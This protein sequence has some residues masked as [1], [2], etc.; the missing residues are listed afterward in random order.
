MFQIL[1]AGKKIEYRRVCIRWVAVLNK[2]NTLNEMATYDVLEE[3]GSAMF[4][5]TSH[6]GGKREERK[7]SD[8]KAG[9]E[10]RKAEKTLGS[11]VTEVK[12]LDYTSAPTIWCI[13][14]K[15]HWGTPVVDDKGH[16]VIQNYCA[17]C[18]HFDDEHI[19]WLKSPEGLAWSEEQATQEQALFYYGSSEWEADV[20]EAMEEQRVRNEQKWLRIAALEHFLFTLKAS[21]VAEDP[22]DY[23]A[24]D[25]YIPEIDDNFDD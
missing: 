11:V 9:K 8:R 14:R 20:I 17:D 7:K 1:V 13:G 23:V 22:N 2:S 4:S 19:K 6:T 21:T 10:R 5:F 16:L 15:G 12:S 3:I 18:K 24:E 25:D